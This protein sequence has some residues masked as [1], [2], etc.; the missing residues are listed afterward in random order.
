MRNAAETRE[1]WIFAGDLEALQK[2]GSKLIKGG[3]AV[4]FI[5]R[6]RSMRSIT[7]VLI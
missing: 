1:G 5:M 2:E 7:A 3:I 4:F 6:I